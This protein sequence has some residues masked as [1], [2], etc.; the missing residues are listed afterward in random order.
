MR[1]E[2]VWKNWIFGKISDEINLS[3]KYYFYPIAKSRMMLVTHAIAVIR[4]NA[5]FRPFLVMFV[6]NEHL[7]IFLFF[8]NVQRKRTIS[9]RTRGTM[10][11]SDIM[12]TNERHQ[13][14]IR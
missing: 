12:R 10:W 1:V 2:K 9:I 14:A 4:S 8:F 13:R 5:L 6:A 3:N 7:F 11:K